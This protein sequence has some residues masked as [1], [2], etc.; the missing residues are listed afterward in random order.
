MKRLVVKR[1]AVKRLAVKKLAAE[2]LQFRMLKA[3][4][5]GAGWVSRFRSVPDGM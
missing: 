1:L 5:T 4:R 2:R 3:I